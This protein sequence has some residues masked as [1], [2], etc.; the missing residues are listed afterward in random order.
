MVADPPRVLVAPDKLKG[1][2]SAREA[3]DACVR[4]FRT[5]GGAAEA[6]PLAGGGEGL[7]EVLL[8]ALGGEWRTATVED[9]LGRPVEARFG[10]LADGRAVVEAAEAI[11]LWRLAPDELDPLSA[12]SRGLGQLLGA[13]AGAGASSLV[14]GLG[15]S[16][17]VDG[18]AGLR[19]TLDAP[20]RPTEG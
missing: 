16:A 10:L 1:V 17:T 7:C 14:V 6:L 11:G 20:P 9:A 13:A 5:A 12:S 8:D 3:A 18:G 19:E 4:G 15:G 2:L